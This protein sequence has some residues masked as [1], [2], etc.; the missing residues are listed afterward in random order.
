MNQILN[1]WSF[2]NMLI[3][4]KT[5]QIINGNHDS[6]IKYYNNII[7]KEIS[8]RLVLRSDKYMVF[9]AH[10]HQGDLFCREKSFLSCLSCCASQIKSTLEDLI[11]ENLDAQ[12]DKLSACLV[13]TDKEITDYAFKVAEAGPYDCVVFGHTH[14]PLIKEKNKKIYVNE[15]CVTNGTET[16]NECAIDINDDLVI[17]NRAVNI[18]TGEIMAKEVATIRK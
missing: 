16:L 7:N 15:G 17:E 8:D 10:G 18:V 9:I 4:D 11:D 13:T 14:N 3:E 5:I 1:S 12:A 2:G 6:L